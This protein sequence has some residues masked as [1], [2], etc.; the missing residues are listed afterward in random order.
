VTAAAIAR[1]PDLDRGAV[2]A[3]YERSFTSTVM[4]NAYVDVYTRLLYS[5]TPATGASAAPGRRPSRP[6]VPTR[7]ARST[8]ARR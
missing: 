3:A 2:R 1:I 4:A 6:G 8:A 5:D 7:Q